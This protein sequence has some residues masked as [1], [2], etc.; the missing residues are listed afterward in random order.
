MFVYRSLKSKNSPDSQS[1]DILSLKSQILASHNNVC[2]DSHLQS[3]INAE[4]VLSSRKE[5]VR[6]H[7]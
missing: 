2:S 1:I 6:K 4:L 5:K 7:N 3:H